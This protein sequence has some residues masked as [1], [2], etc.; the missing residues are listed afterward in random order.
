MVAL[1]YGFTICLAS[2]PIKCR[3]YITSSLMPYKSSMTELLGATLGSVLK[4]ASKLSFFCTL[5]FIRLYIQSYTYNLCISLSLLSYF[6][7]LAVRIS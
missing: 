1:K 3:F 6:C 4:Y 7:C 5:K 2:S